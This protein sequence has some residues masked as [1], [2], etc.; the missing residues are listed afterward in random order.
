M[1]I[2][3]PPAPIFKEKPK[4]KKKNEADG[5]KIKKI[6]NGNGG[7][8]SRAAVAS[9]SAEREKYVVKAEHPQGC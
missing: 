8:D 1:L 5:N 7:S 6:L 2:A 9:I 4:K 3:D